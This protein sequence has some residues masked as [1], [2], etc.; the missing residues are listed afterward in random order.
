[1]LLEFFRDSNALILTRSLYYKAILTVYKFFNKCNVE[2][3][4]T[5]F[6]ELQ[7]N[8]ILLI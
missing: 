2:N 1:M 4:L 3:P 6:N 8:I 5:S 7:L